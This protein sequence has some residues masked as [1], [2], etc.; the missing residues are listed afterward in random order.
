MSVSVRE[1]VR[2]AI[3]A[4]AL[5][6]IAGPARARELTLGVNGQYVFNS[7]FFSAERNEEEANSFQIGP[8][9]GIADDEDRFQYSLDFQGAYQLYVDQSGVDNWESRLQA[10]ASYDL[11][12][13]TRV[14]VTNQFRDIS[15]LRF[16][17]QDITLGDTA[18]DPNQV[19]YFRNDLELMLLH[20]LTRLLELRVRGE[21]HWVDFEENIDRNDSQAW[22][23]GA[24][25]RY[26][27]APR[28]FLGTG[29]AY[30]NQDFQEAFSRFGSRAE[31]VNSYLTWVWD[32]ADTVTFTA[33]GGPSWIQAEE[34]ERGHVLQ[35]RFVGG[36]VRGELFRADIDTCDVQLVGGVPQPVASRCDLTT[37]GAAFAPIPATDLGGLDRFDLTN[38]GRVGSDSTLTFFGN[39]SLEAQ[40]AA[41]D[42]T[43]TYSRRQS[44]TAGDAL[45]SS[46]DRAA[47]QL[48]YGPPGERWSVFVAG[49]W[50]RREVLTDSTVVDFVVVDAD[51]PSGNGD[52]STLRSTGFTRVQQRNARRDNFTAIAGYRH[53]LTRHLS[54]TAEFRYRRTERRNSGIDLPGVDTFFLVFS[55][56]YDLDPIRF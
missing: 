27:L 12:T 41:L 10:R 52:D 31:Y 20:D 14:R 4:L 49:S 11:T 30:V 6:A 25:L 29:L 21:H 55:V 33:S 46:L 17:R 8:R 28:H 26:R 51:A 3:L 40:L 1:S 7:N 45:A 19:R 22:E 56:D 48:E 15:N 39:A 23:V 35:T 43:A 36:R 24:E 18:L 54:G 16:S 13:R 37:P 5:L 32:I 9:L 42:L 34:K 2:V 44:T 38:L 50:D 53:E 47:L